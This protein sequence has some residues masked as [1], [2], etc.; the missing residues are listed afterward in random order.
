MHADETQVYRARPVVTRMFPLTV[1]ETGEV[2][3]PQFAYPYRPQ[4]FPPWMD[5]F[6]AAAIPIVVVLLAQIRVRSFW[7]ANNAIIG[8]IYA[9]L[10]SSCF[11]VFVKWLVGGLRPHFYDVCKPDPAL[12]LQQQA[13]FNTNGLN[14]VG[15]QGYMYTPEVCTGSQRGVGNALESFPS[16]HATTIFAGMVFL[17][18]YL[19]AKLKVFSNYHPA[20]W[21]LVILYLP[22][23]FACL[24]AG[25]LTI[26][27]SH[28]WYDIIAGAIIG[29]IFALSAYRMV[30]AAIWDYRM[31]HIPLNRGS[32]FV[33]SEGCEGSD[34]VFTDKAGWKDG[35]LR[36]QG[37]LPSYNGEINGSSFLNGRAGA[38]EAN[39]GGDDMV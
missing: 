19:N 34:M 9:L 17:Y 18:L 36:E 10:A 39:S 8:L 31:N 12:A 7:D 37:Q 5:A 32:P 35:S 23:L 20:M 13:S 15:Y 28:N 1:R 16:G 21:K 4:V 2:V 11:Q 6:L 22:I 29:I 27:Y 3:W 14:G 33:W 30:Y 25:T 24:V 38:R 26:D